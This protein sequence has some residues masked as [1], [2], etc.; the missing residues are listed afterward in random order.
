[1]LHIEES[2]FE[3][4]DMGVEWYVH[5]LAQASDCKAKI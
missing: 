2:A 4:M 5:V 1:M 3:R